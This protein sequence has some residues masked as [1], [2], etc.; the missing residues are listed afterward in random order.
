MATCCRTPARPARISRRPCVARL[1]HIV[2]FTRG[3]CRKARQAQNF[4]ARAFGD[5][6]R[7]GSCIA[8]Q[9]LAMIRNRIVDVGADTARVQ[10][11]TQ[12]LAS[13]G[14]HNGKM[15]DTIFTRWRR[16][17]NLRMA[18]ALDIG[19][20][21]PPP[22]REVRAEGVGGA[23][24]GALGHERHRA[25]RDPV[26]WRDPRCVP[27]VAL[28]GHTVVRSNIGNLPFNFRKL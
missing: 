7:D 14:T 24:D 20:E 19:A 2:D 18:N 13:G 25:R 28:H 11:S 17:A 6:Q 8:C 1:D 22:R 4:A 21:D 12:R 23:D 26:V 5:R 10:M 9:W 27:L 3:H 15:C 16:H